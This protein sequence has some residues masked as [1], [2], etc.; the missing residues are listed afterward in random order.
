MAPGEKNS[1]KGCILHCLVKLV[2]SIWGQL[3]DPG[4]L[5]DEVS[6]ILLFILG[7]RPDFGYFKGHGDERKKGERSEPFTI[8]MFLKYS[9][10]VVLKV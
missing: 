8:F 1:M 2:L 4:I 3:S 5:P 10:E 6:L 9:R 7:G